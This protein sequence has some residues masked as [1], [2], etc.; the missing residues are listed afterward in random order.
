[1]A[2]FFSFA[3]TGFCGY[4][5]F[6]SFIKGKGHL[7]EVIKVIE[8]TMLMDKKEVSGWFAECE[9]T[10][11][12]VS[13]L[14]KRGFYETDIIYRQPPLIGM[15]TYS[16]EQAPILHFIYKELGENFEQPK[17]RV[18]DFLEG[19]ISIFTAVYGIND[20][21]HSEYYKYIENQININIYVNWKMDKLLPRC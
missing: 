7:L 4:L 15:P 18:D 5:A 3:K 8:R 11:D 16:F 20:P 13:I 14:K 1:M 12:V 21:K 19:L 6:D 17:L 9:P 10:N 2:S